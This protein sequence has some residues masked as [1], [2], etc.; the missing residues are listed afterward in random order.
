MGDVAGGI[1][2][3]MGIIFVHLAALALVPRFVRAH[4]LGFERETVLDNSLVTISAA[5]A[6]DGFDVYSEEEYV[7]AGKGLR[8]SGLYEDDQ[9]LA[10]VAEWIGHG[11]LCHP[12]A[13]EAA[14]RSGEY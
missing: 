4:S 11:C 2:A 7:L 14:R 1:T 13:D 8:H 5:A 12:T 10:G 9:V 3:I 6:P